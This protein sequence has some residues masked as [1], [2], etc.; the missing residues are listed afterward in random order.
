MKAL[1][2]GS[3]SILVFVTKEHDVGWG[4]GTFKIYSNLE[5]PLIIANRVRETN[6]L[7]AEEPVPCNWG[8]DNQRGRESLM[9]KTPDPFD[10]RRIGHG[11]ASTPGGIVPNRWP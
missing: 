9:S 11:A 5:C 2:S 7:G 10:F 3:V 1:T 8:G 6:N 4:K